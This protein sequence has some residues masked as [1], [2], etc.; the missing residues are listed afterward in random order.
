MK[1]KLPGVAED[2]NNFMPEARLHRL[3]SL[4]D[5]QCEQMVSAKD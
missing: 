2:A 4:V 3:S 1:L 5:F